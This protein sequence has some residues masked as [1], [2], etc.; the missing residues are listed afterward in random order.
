MKRT[1][2]GRLLALMCVVTMVTATFLTWLPAKAV[3]STVITVDDKLEEGFTPWTFSDVEIEDQTLKGDINWTTAKQ[4][5]LDKTIFNGKILFPAGTGN[6]LGNFYIGGTTDS[7]DSLYSGFLIRGAGA[8]EHLSISFQD[9]TGTIHNIANLAQ[10]STTTT[11]RGN[12]ELQISLSVEYTNV[13]SDGLVDMQVGVFFNGQLYGNQYFTV[14][15]MPER[16]LTQHIKWKNPK[17]NTVLKSHSLADITLENAPERYFKEWTFSDLGKADSAANWDNTTAISDS[18]DQTLFRGKIKFGQESG[19]VTYIGGTGSSTVDDNTKHRG[20]RFAASGEDLVVGFMGTAGHFFNASGDTGS[21]LASS[22]TLLVTCTNE[23]AETTLVNNSNLEVAVSVRYLNESNGVA[24]IEIGLFFDGKLYNNTYYKVAAIPTTYLHQNVAVNYG[25]VSSYKMTDIYLENAPEREFDEWSLDDIG[26]ADQ[27]NLAGVNINWSYP[28]ATA[29][30]LNKSLFSCK[31]YIPDGGWNDVGQFYIG[32]S[33][34]T[35]SKMEC[36]FRIRGNINKMW[37][38]DFVDKTGSQVSV[39]SINLYSATAGTDLRANR[40]LLFQMSVEVLSVT[41]GLATVKIGLFFDGKLYNNQYFTLSGLD[42]SCLTRHVKWG[43]A[44]N[45][46]ALASHHSFDITLKNAPE[47]NFDYWTLRDINISDTKVSGS[48]NDTIKNTTGLDK[49]IFNAKINFAATSGGFGQVYIGGSQDENGS[50]GFQLRSWDETTVR[51]AFM[52]TDGKLY[53]YNGATDQ[54]IVTF[55]SKKAG[56]Q[57]RGNSNLQFSLSVEIIGGSRETISG[58]EC[59]DIKVGAFFDGKLYD[60]TYYT[61]ADV[62]EK[63]LTQNI[64]WYSATEGCELASLAKA[65]NVLLSNNATI[66]TS[67][68]DMYSENTGYGVDTLFDGVVGQNDPYYLGA[69]GADLQNEPM[70]FDFA[71]G[72]A[73]SIDSVR[74]HKYRAA[75]GFPVDFTISAYTV[76]GW[77]TVVTKTDYQS[78]V[79]WNEFNFADTVCSAV[80]LTVTENGKHAGGDTF[81]MHLTEFEAWGVSA[82][83]ELCAP[84]TLTEEATVIAYGK[85]DVAINDG[86]LTGNDGFRILASSQEEKAKMQLMFDFPVTT[87]G[88]QISAQEAGEFPSAFTI[89]AFTGSGWTAVHTE[90]AY[91]P[92][93]TKTMHEFQFDSPVT[94]SSIMVEVNSMCDIYDAGN[95]YGLQIQEIRMNGAKKVNDCTLLG[96][97]NVDKLLTET[98]DMAAFRTALA[99][100]DTPGAIYDVNRD[101]ANDCRDLVRMKR[102]FV[103]K[104]KV[105][106]TYDFTTM[107]LNVR[108]I[109]SD[110]SGYLHPSV[111]APY[112]VDYLMESGAELIGLQEVKELHDTDWREI[113]CQGMSVEGSPYQAIGADDAKHDLLIFYNAEKFKLKNSG[114]TELSAIENNPY[115]YQWAEFTDMRSGETIFMTNTHFLPN[116]NAS[117]VVEDQTTIR[118]TEAEELLAFWKNT[119]KDEILVA[120]GDYNCYQESEPANILTSDIYEEVNVGLGEFA[121]L[122]DHID[123]AFFNPKQSEVKQFYFDEGT[124]TYTDGTTQYLSD[125]LPLLVKLSYKYPR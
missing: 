56:V 11:L 109:H 97:G 35:T 91:T 81:G 3:D 112:I 74:L 66:S 61:V 46:A 59:V 117:G 51:L 57:L 124:F 100:S 22:T 87:D 39:S 69:V 58:Q 64:R 55:D 75:D 106:K 63:Y 101:E 25:Y 78:V 40:N 67:H 41:D 9:A 85:N 24:D 12:C 10:S 45:N 2:K 30:T 123:H 93:A 116:Y 95:I 88:I 68:V 37:A 90:T 4:S 76:D 77:K 48:W 86:I 120:V 110:S 47:N 42:E 70:T 36:G 92:N 5:S 20:I 121:T 26:I 16:C 31:L 43:G 114:V 94:C 103:N 108:C 50:R 118:N 15:S 17:N 38:F 71:F 13:T 28:A 1:I 49:T 54:A 119:V 79:G 104:D 52:G 72:D 122:K 98:E 80:R 62:P 60:N 27:D 99:G 33:S 73:Y 111:R 7:E 53:N 84:Y 102:Y 125:Q 105:Q 113:L 23:V 107:S 83:D 115:Y 34:D 21:G 44:K 29:K 82:S 89:Y 19:G 14:K 96:D 6:D 65:E 18:L 32:G 8:S